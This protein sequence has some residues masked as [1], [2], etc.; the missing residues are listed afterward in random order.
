[1]NKLIIIGESHTR[2]FTHRKNVLPF[3]M[4]AGKVI[5]L[6]DKNIKNINNQ[7][8]KINNNIKDIDLYTTFIYLGEPNCRFPLKN[9]WTP[10]WD[11]IKLGKKVKSYV[12]KEYLKKCVNN[13]DKIDL[14]HID[15]IITPTG[16]YDPVQPA[17]KYFNE[18]LE[19]KFGGK[20][21]NIFEKT[22]DNDLKTLDQY[23]AINWKEDPIHTNS[24]VS[25]DLLDILKEKNIINNVSDYESDIDGYFGTHLLRN[26]DKSRFGSYIIKK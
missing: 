8:K 1:M 13:F 2:Q 6:E 11:E 17:L 9:H 20:V 14:S 19:K 10:H 26:V 21:I 22:V 16:A 12:S 5:N 7:L 18:L 3:F 15:Y 25:E 23:K 4:G 24:K